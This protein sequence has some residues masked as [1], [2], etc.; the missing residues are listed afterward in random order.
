M[1]IYLS[2]VLSLTGFAQCFP[3]STSNPIVKRNEMT[4]PGFD[5]SFPIA[6]YRDPYKNDP[7]SRNWIWANPDWSQEQNLR[8]KH[9]RGNSQ[10][11]SELVKRAN[12]GEALSDSYDS[13]SPSQLKTQHEAK[14]LT[15]PNQS[16]SE[17]PVTGSMSWS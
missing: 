7:R 2:F 17:T 16:F 5:E 1:H 3:T 10:P 13:P 12:D 8:L 4:C 11:T 6:S 15:I 14:K 9:R